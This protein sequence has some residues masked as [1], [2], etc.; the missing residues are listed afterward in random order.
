MVTRAF[1]NIFL[2]IT[3]SVINDYAKD[4]L[5]SLMNCAILGFQKTFMAS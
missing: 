3:I 4:R 5:C 2:L 1:G